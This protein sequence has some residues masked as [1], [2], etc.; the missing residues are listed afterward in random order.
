LQGVSFVEA[1]FTEVGGKEAPKASNMAVT[2]FPN[3]FTGSTS[4]NVNLNKS[5]Q[6]SLVV[7]SLTG[8]VV[9]NVNYGV[10]GAGAQTLTF[11][12]SNLNSGIYF[13]TVTIGDQ[14]ATN[15]MIIK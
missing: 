11:D 13:Y 9:S 7:N 15:K 3:P 5:A 1:D 8:Q 2:N 10:M 6:V 12:A 4:I 14:K